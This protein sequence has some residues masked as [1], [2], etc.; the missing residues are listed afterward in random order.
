MKKRKL[1][2]DNCIARAVADRLRADGHDV[3]SIVERGADPGDAA[4]LQA[5]FAEGRALVTIDVDFGALVF[6]DDAKHAGVLRLRPRPAAA[7]ADRASALVIS[8][9]HELEA[10]AFVT[11]D[12]DSVRVTRR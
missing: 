4:I 2:L 1:L 11:D 8:H 5:A 6:R 7:L 3:A 9:G 10:G 12:G